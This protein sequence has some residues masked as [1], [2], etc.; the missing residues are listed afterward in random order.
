MLIS[1]SNK[2]RDQHVRDAVYLIPRT[3]VWPPAYNSYIY[4][5]IYTE[6]VYQNYVA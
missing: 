5:W 2:C 4:D 3:L 6:K 1:F